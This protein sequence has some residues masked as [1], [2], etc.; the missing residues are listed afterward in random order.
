MFAAWV[1]NCGVSVP[2]DVIGEPETVGLKTTPSP[3]IPTLVTVPLPV[4]ELETNMVRTSVMEVIAVL[5]VTTIAI[6][7]FEPVK[8]VVFDPG[9]QLFAALRNT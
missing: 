9:A 7:M 3:V 6:G 4:C 2:L 1:S 8:P 5:E